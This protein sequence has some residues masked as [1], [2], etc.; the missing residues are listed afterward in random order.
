MHEAALAETLL[1]Q[2]T[3]IRDERRL[4]RIQDVTIQLGAFSGIEPVSLKTAFEERSQKWLGAV[5]ELRIE[6]V[7]LRAECGACG[8]CFDVTGFR[9]QCPCCSAVDVRIVQGENLMLLS[10]RA[11]IN[12]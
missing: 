1:R 9:F 2:V 4:K 12:S 10:L 5:A 8:C 11:E 6:S 3:E 7:E